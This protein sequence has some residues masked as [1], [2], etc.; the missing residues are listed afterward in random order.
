LRRDLIAAVEPSRKEESSISYDL[1]VDQNDPGRFV[2]I[3]HWARSRRAKSIT[4]RPP[5]FS[6]S[7]RTVRATWKPWS[8]PIF[9]RRLRDPSHRLARVVR[10]GAVPMDAAVA[11]ELQKTW[12]RDA[13][14]EWAEIDT[15]RCH[16]RLRRW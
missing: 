5:T 11:P 12:H 9:S 15:N 7:R 16:L 3:E 2:F 10:A 8:S 14:W 13:A 6:I 4:M 1:F